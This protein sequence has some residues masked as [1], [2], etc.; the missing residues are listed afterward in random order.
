MKVNGDLIKLYP[1]TIDQFRAAQGVLWNQNAEF[2]T[3]KLK[4]ELPVKIEVKWGV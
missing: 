4:N 1:L 3:M 2:F